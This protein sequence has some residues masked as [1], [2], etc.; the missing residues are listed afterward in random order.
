MSK[1]PSQFLTITALA[2]VLLLSQL[3]QGTQEGITN[4]QLNDQSMIAVNW[5]Q[6]SGEY[7]A[8]AYQA[9]NIAKLTFDQA[10]SKDIS[11]PAII[12][13]IDETVLD[14]SPYQAGLFDSDNVFQPDTWNQWVKEA[15]NKSIPGALE[16]VNYVNSNG[17]KVFFISDRDGKR[18]N[19]YQKSAVETATI[20][21]LKSVGFTGVNEQTVLLK[22]KFS[23]I[24]DGKENTSKQWRIEAVKNGSADGKKYT[25]IAL[26]GDNLNDFDE[27]AGK[28]N[29]QRRDHVDKN[30]NFYGVLDAI[31]NGVIEPAYIA[32]PN[33]MYGNWETGMYNPQAFKKQSP[34]E[35]SPGEKNQQRKESLNRWLPK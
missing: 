10:K 11:R 33:P 23:K 8:L 5:V 2:P 14:N 9:F 6:Q 4:Q 20:S 3:Q 17:G 25:V 21:N 32:I 24:I 34:L 22:G 13:D 35:M 19:K 29:Q 18:V 26:I 31:P 28:K 16:F 12:V 7:R 30:R 1:L 27:T 15:K